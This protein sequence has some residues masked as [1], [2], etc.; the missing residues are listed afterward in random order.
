MGDKVTTRLPPWVMIHK[1]TMDHST[2]KVKYYVHVLLLNRIFP[3]MNH[4][5]AWL[6]FDL[7]HAK[8]ILPIF[9]GIISMLFC[10]IIVAT[11]NVSRGALFVQIRGQNFAHE[12]KIIEWDSSENPP[13]VFNFLPECHLP[14]GGVNGWCPS[15]EVPRGLTKKRKHFWHS[16]LSRRSNYYGE[17][18]FDPCYTCKFFP[19]HTYTRNKRNATIILGPKGPHLMI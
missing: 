2:N 1:N 11:Q 16:S 13:F 19:T 9:T 8:N 17:R 4:I 14:F 10:S 12:Y 18:H 6:T 5:P 3:L 7:I 15:S